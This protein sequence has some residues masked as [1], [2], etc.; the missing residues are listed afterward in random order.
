M[1]SN[2]KVEDHRP[3]NVTIKMSQLKKKLKPRRQV[4]GLYDERGSCDGW[5]F[6]G[7]G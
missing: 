3:L 2:Q 1:A 4:E 6:S 5:R 7:F